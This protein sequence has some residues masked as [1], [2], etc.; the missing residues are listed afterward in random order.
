[1]N[2]NL[3]SVIIP[4][5]NRASTIERAI[6]SVLIQKYIGEII[7]VDDG[8]NDNGPAIVDSLSK[9]NN[10]IKLVMTNSNM[11]ASHARNIGIKIAKYEL[12]AFLDSD[13][14]WLPNKIEKQIYLLNSD[15]NTKLVY[16]GLITINDKKIIKEPGLTFE[17]PFLT[18]LHWNYIGTTSSIL[19]YKDIL[20]DVGLFDENLQS[21]N[22]LDLWLRIS[23]KYK[24]N[25]IEQPLVNFYQNNADRITYNYNKKIQ[26]FL[27]FINK[28]YNLLEKYPLSLSKNYLKL[29]KF[30]SD[31][32]E[33]N[34]AYKYSR[35]AIKANINIKSLKYFSYFSIRRYI[36]R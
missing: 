35:L 21:R 28:H 15:K 11:G 34:N 25:C 14:E 29:A 17:I 32:N 27:G 23:L 31:N 6:N 5:Y 12:I 33:Y 36:Y 10:L 3:V 2:I 8:S 1:M 16:T 19:C 9:K 4:L 18:L 20:F 24:I 30:Y 22:D 13:D 26:G 7:V